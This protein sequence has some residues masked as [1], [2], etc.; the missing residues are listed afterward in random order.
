MYIV[1]IQKEDFDVA[2]VPMAKVFTLI[3]RHVKQWIDLISTGVF[4]AKEIAIVKEMGNDIENE[5]I[6][7][8]TNGEAAAK[9]KYLKML[10]QILSVIRNIP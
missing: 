9:P 8:N 4:T 10:N 6:R 2:K 1:C 5:I 3:N 7:V